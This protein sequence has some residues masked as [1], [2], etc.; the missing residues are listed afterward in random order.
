MMGSGKSALGRSIADISGREFIDTDILVQQTVC[1]PIS[2]V[3]KLYGEDAFREHESA[4]LRKLEP[5]GAVVSTGGGIVIRPENWPQ[6]RRLGTT[7]YL[8][9]PVDALIERLERSKKRRPLLEG[10]QWRERLREI[11]EQR[12]PLYRQADLTVRVGGKDVESTAREVLAAL[13][14]AP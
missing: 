3:F 6:L 8:E 4:V 1:R 7:L 2:Q 9:A 10:P 13:E 12:E 11:L 5:C 14:T